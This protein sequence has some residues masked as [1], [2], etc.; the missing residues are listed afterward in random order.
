MWVDLSTSDVDGGR[1]FY[2]S[3]FGWEAQDLGPDAGGYNMMQLRG[4]MVAGLGPVMNPQQPSAWN[5]Y[6]CT[7]DAR[8]TAEKVRQAGGQVVMEPF[9]VMGQGHM[10]VFQDPGGA[11]IAVWQPGQHRGAEIVN[12]P[13][14]FSWNELAT[15]D[16]DS[17]KR[18]Y[19]Q[20]FGWGNETHGDYTEWKVGGRSIGGA[21]P[22]GDRYPP[23]VPPH[24][25]VYFTVED[26]DSSASKAQQLGGQVV[27]PPMDIEPGRFAMIRDPQG[28]A[29]GIYK[30][31]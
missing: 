29:F 4:K 22:M 3:F 20:V 1:R 25:L 21:M 27:V 13:N 23:Q 5:T 2:T 18:F 15:R 26:V 8:A 14:S 10:G 11:Y 6:V 28:A 9:D 31:K 7:L 17:A 24:W 19:G 16:I 30:P 12:E